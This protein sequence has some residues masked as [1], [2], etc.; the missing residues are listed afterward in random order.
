MNDLLRRAL[1]D[2]DLTEEDVAAR[3]GIDL[4]TVRRWVA[5]RMPYP[6]NRRALA[7]LLGADE[8]DLWPQA[9][10]PR[11]PLP[12]PP[13]LEILA[14][15]PHRWAVPR[16][17]WQQHF[18]SAGREIGILAYAGLFL[19]EDTG[20]LR[21][22]LDKA[23]EG[24]GVRVLLGDP[25]GSHVSV[26]GADEG[27][28]ESL[29][30]K[31]RNALV[32]YRPLCDVESVEIRLHDTVLYNSIYLADE[33]LLVNPHA[34]GVTASHA[35]VMRLRHVRDSDMASVYLDSFERVWTGAN[36]LCG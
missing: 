8:A 23:R 2:A 14:T 6:R 28:G 10:L 1:A 24:V 31:I 34:Y 5:G 29:A 21:V 3:I 22:L 35:P 17:V 26:R 33:D 13:A 9:A 15:Y 16:S 36:P 30:A 4:K 18:E 12:E 19:A 11:V 20:L 25:E 32:L 27:V 7:G